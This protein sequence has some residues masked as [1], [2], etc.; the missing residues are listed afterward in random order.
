MSRTVKPVDLEFFSTLA[1]S[2]SLTATAQKLGLTTAAVSKRLLAM[3]ARVGV[4]LINRTTRRM[5]LTPEGEV[6]FDHA[7]HILE[8]VD[9]LSELLGS[10]QATPKGLLRVYATLGFGR[11]RVGPLIS[12]F[13]SEY[14][15][16]SVQLQLSAAPPPLTEDAFDVC[17]LFGEPPDARVVARRLSSNRRLLCAAPAYVARRGTPQTPRD[18]SEHNCIGIF[19]GN[20][21][22][23]I[24]RLTHRRD[25]D[26]KPEIVRINGNLATN[27]GET[28]VRW[29][30]DG[31][32]ILMRAEWDIREYLLDGLLVAVLPDYQTQSADIYAVYPRQH[33]TSA[34]VRAFVAF[35]AAALKK[36]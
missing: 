6:L 3:E 36:D 2:S 22:Y 25:P 1:R 27:D 11:K 9:H 18:L 16:V 5:T 32:G 13:V 23:G 7:R 33:L 21:A 19:Q 31:R 30:L 20:Q 26:R 35:L 8:E 34:R 4:P 28:A 24:W 12:S 14:P 15:E 17:I 29:A 10:A